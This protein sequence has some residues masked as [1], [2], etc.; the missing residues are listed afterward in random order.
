MKNIKAYVNIKTEYDL[1]NLR[2]KVLEEKEKQLLKEK[3]SL[4]ELKVKLYDI[5]NQIEEKL[6]E[7]QGIERELF[8]EI[9][10]KGTNVTRAVDKVSITYDVDPSTIWKY[11]YPKIKDVIKR[12]E[13][14]AKSSEILV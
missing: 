9:I 6:K 10:V 4:E 13:T 8:Y 14:E 11:Y 5:L 12:I 3:I 1:I 2:I 7:L